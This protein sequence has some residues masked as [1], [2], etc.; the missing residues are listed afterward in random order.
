MSSIG[1]FVTSQDGTQIWADHTGNT[2]MPAVILIAGFSCSALVFEKQWKDQELL[3]HLHL[4]DC[5][6]EPLHLV[7]LIRSR[8]DM[9]SEGRVR[10]ISLKTKRH[11]CLH[12]KLKI[13]KQFAML[14]ICTNHL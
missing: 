11:T 5:I 12:V 10:V 14:L 8:F 2:K 4:V 1:Q 6:S 9:M 7:F 3:Q 13:S